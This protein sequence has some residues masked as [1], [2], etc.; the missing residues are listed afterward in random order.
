MQEVS[1]RLH[2]TLAASSD[3][4]KNNMAP[5]HTCIND[6]NLEDLKTKI[7]KLGRNVLVMFGAVGV[8]SILV[9]FTTIQAT[10]AQEA[11]LS[12]IRRIEEVKARVDVHE[13][14]FKHILAG[15]NRI[16]EKLDKGPK[17]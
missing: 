5:T 14:R 16:E 4:D 2:K 8:F 1:G 15:I 6:K 10:R 9:A 7:G 13:E 12:T 17:K 11:S 3:K